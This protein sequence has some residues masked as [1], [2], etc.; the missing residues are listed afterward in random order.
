MLFG[1]LSPTGGDSQKAKPGE[2]K[3]VYSVYA[4]V[5]GGSEELYGSHA[6][7]AFIFEIKKDAH[8]VLE[9]VTIGEH[10]FT[11]DSTNKTH[12][13]LRLDEIYDGGRGEARFHQM[14]LP[15]PPDRKP[16]KPGVAAPGKEV[17]FKLKRKGKN[18]HYT[19]TRYDY[20]NHQN[21][22]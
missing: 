2:F 5:S 7:T 17:V 18:L 9:S 4:S 21:A 14:F 6:N 16:Q 10:V 3:V 8:T 11:I 15:A 12:F 13:Q 22:P 19:L 20:I 1:F